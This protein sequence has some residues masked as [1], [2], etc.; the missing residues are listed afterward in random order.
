MGFLSKHKSKHQRNGRSFFKRRK[1]RLPC[2]SSDDLRATRQK[3]TSRNTAGRL[4]IPMMKYVRLKNETKK[5]KTKNNRN[6]HEQ[7]ALLLRSKR[8]T[9]LRV[10]A[11]DET[12]DRRSFV[13]IRFVRF[14][15]ARSASYP[16][17]VRIHFP[18]LGFI[19]HLFKFS[20]GRRRV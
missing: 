9:T 3:Q 2:M 16:G 20:Q 17:H 5:K 11:T 1:N 15:H 4:R 18:D 12:R 10:S 7:N 13:V 8:L 19:A 6:R 14:I